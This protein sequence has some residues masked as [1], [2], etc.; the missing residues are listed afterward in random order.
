MNT[1]RNQ[2]GLTTLA[3]IGIVAGLIILGLVTWLLLKP[4]D[5]P[6]P[7]PTT[8]QNQTSPNATESE[9]EELAIGNNPDSIAATHTVTYT[10]SGFSP[11]SLTIKQGDTVKFVNQSDRDFSPAS[12]DH[13]SHTIYAG[14]DARE[15][16]G[17]GESYSFTF[18]R[19]GNW[20]YHNHELEGHTG[21]I[22]VEG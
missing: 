22:V 10:N 18:D 12:N 5:E 4:T 6:E 13:P 11:T 14:F 15:D 3:S 1:A 19:V 20:G 21:T 7:A 16:L 9:T 8:A 17:P 2:A